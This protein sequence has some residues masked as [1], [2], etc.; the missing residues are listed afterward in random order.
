MITREEAVRVLYA[1]TNSGIIADDLGEKLHD[2]IKCIQS[3]DR[4]NDFGI[5]IW[6]AKEDDWIDLYVSRR[7]DLITPEWEQHQRDVYEKY[8]IKENPRRS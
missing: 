2:I 8:R 1:V 7:V 4:E 5:D 6:G 3:G